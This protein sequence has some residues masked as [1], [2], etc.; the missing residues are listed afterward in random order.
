MSVLK[1]HLEFPLDFTFKI[2]GDKTEQ[3][4]FDVKEVF[5]D[6]PE[7]TIAPKISSNG[8]Y[9]SYSVTVYLESYEALESL[10]TRISTLNGLKF[11]C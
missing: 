3:F 10:Y 5:S 8:A 9:I 7:K 1:E 2:V 11:H 4:D 6:Y